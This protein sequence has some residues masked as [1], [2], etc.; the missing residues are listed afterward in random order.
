MRTT[1]YALP[2]KPSVLALREAYGADVVAMI[3]GRG[4]YCGVG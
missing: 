2:A 4:Q 1:I 3:V